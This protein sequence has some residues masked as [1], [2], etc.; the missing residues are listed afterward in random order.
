VTGIPNGYPQNNGGISYGNATG[1]SLSQIVTG[2]IPGNVYVLEFWCGGE[3]FG[4]WQYPG[5]FGLDIGFGN[6]FLHCPPT[7]PG[8]T[9]LRY[10]VQF[11]ATSTTHVVKFTNWGHKCQQ[12]TEVI[13]DDVRMYPINQ[14]S[15]IIPACALGVDEEVDFGVSVFQNPKTNQLEINSATDKNL[16]LVVYNMLSGKVAEIKFINTAE[17]NLQNLSNGIYV[18]EVT[19]GLQSIRKNKFIVMN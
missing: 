3:F 6:T 18:Y 2:L 15:S 9:G 4:T 11:A 5:V 14:L 16:K 19:N 8:D 12:C 7:G 17:L 10:I 13:L 1:V